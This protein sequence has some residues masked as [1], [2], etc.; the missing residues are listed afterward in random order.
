[1]AALFSAVA[2]IAPIAAGAAWLK[3]DQRKASFARFM[4]K[5]FEE[6]E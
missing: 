1:M 3:N 4:D 5:F 6:N 2:L